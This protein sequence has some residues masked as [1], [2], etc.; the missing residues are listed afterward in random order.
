[1]DQELYSWLDKEFRAS[2]HTK[3]HKYCK[4]WLDN[5]TSS[6][7]EVFNKQMIAVLTNSLVK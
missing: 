1:M 4:E 3:Y 2:N 7:I 6:Q 5:I